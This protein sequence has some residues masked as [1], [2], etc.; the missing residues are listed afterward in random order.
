VTAGTYG[1]GSNPRGVAAVDVNGDG[2]LDLVSADYNSGQ[3]TVFTNNGSGGFVFV[4][5][6]PV[7]GSP[8]FVVAADVN[9]DGKVDMITPDY[10]NKLSVLTNGTPF[11]PAT[12]PII[13]TQPAGQ[14]NSVGGTAGFSVGVTA[15]GGV[16]LFTYQWR[17]AG[18]NLPAATNNN[19][20]LPNLT[21]SQAGSYDVVVTDSAD[22]VTSTP[23]ILDVRFIIVKVNGQIATGTAF[24]VAPATVTLLGGYPGG[25]F[26]YTLDGSAPTT[27]STFY[28]GPITLTNS[29]VI[30]MLT[31]SA[32]FTT[33]VEGDPVTVLVIPT[34]NLQTAITGNGTL[35][36]N[37]ASGPY[38]SNSIVTLT[39]TAA[40][41]WAFDHWTGDATG[42]QNP[43]NVTMNGPRNVQ[44]VFVQSAFPLTLTT[45]GGGGVTANGQV[46]AAATYYPA[47]SIV[48][49]AATTNNG[50]SFLGW[51]GN[52]SGTNNP[53]NLVMNQTNN[54]QA[55]FGTVAA[56]NA[57]GGGVVLSIAN[58][59]PYGTTQTVSAVPDPGNYF[60]T[61]MGSVSGTN[62]P[63]RIAVTS[64]SPSFGALFA[65]LPA[66]KYA[67]NV[68]V[69]GSGFVTNTPQRNYYNSGDTVI[70]RATNNAG[71]FFFGWSQ[72]AMGTNY[73][74][75]NVM[76]ANKTVQANFGV[77]PT[78][79]ISPLNLTILAGSNAV[80]SA[81][82][83]GISPLAYQWQNSQGVVVGATNPIFSFLNTQPT[84]AG[85]YSVVVSNFSGSVTSAVAVVT[86]IGPPTITNQPTL[87]T[88]V[89]SGHGASFVVGA[90]G[91]PAL[92][93]QWRLNGAYVSGAT[94]AAL[95]LLNAFPTN[96][97]IYSVTITNVYGSVTSGPAIL[98]VLPLGITAPARL[99]N[100]QFQF[101]FDTATGLH[102]AVQY[103]TNLTDWYPL[104]TVGGIGLPLTMSDPNMAGNQRRFYRISLL[105]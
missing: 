94:N 103:S 59:I 53:L 96:A 84:N 91:W 15:A 86:V 80:L 2:K 101:T 4:G 35:S 90:Y 49:I 29:A 16:L 66:G 9:G 74:V 38:I 78:V 72:D 34:Y 48:S 37:P 14:T 76:T 54:I 1:V 85:S 24:A 23:A 12:L 61:W 18:T 32:D 55:I 8:N 82:A 11:P 39:A 31:M 70:S 21:L 7:G 64:A 92:T 77:A 89:T 63:I 5:T 57:V 13:T 52:A 104:F 99:P 98:T 33:T 6:Y 65:P 3:L 93:Y 79:S 42:S 60:V 75:T 27:S 87:Q 43:L 46:I 19:L 67:L 41:H 10:E 17:L 20:V 40:L 47:S 105:P 56:T 44:A 30:R 81:S 62:A 50:W 25:Y 45:P 58:P 100:G 88:T 71:A 83:L 102:Y 95:T 73:S 69:N 97:G 51:Q 68:I 28:A 36:T 22:S 26:F